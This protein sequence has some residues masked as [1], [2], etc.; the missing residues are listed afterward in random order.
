MVD[1]DGSVTQYLAGLRA[2]LGGG[3]GYRRDSGLLRIASGAHGDA[4]RAGL[5]AADH[6]RL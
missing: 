6:G 4:R 3:A 1:L 5:H 2:A